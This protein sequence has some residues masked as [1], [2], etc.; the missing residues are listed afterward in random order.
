MTDLTL[1]DNLLDHATTTCRA[2]IETPRGSGAKY[3][4]DP[5]IG[6]CELSGQLP[7]GLVFP[8]D[9][10][11]VPRTC[12]EDGDPLDI[13]VIA[14]EPIAVGTTVRVRLLGIIEARQ[15]ERD[16]RVVRNDRI[17]A[18]VAVSVSYGDAAHIADLGA[19][20]VDHLGRFFT[21]Y[22]DLKG[23]HFEVLGVHGP[24]AAIAAIERAALTERA[25]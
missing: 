14:D 20:F 7:A 25:P 10:G 19:R 22:N 12:G 9:F 3:S 11:F 23:K 18:R 6:A 13:L 5:L 1:I 4:Y 8:L 16:G 21:Q 2:G 15:T 24:E 17:V